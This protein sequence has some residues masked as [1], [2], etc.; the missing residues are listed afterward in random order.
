M[1]LDK[2]I[3]V[4]TILV[5]GLLLVACKTTFPVTSQ[6]TQTHLKPYRVGKYWYHPLPHARDFK[7]QGIASW[8]G[9]YFHGRK[10]SNGEVYDMYGMTAAHK[11]LPLGIYVRV[12]N[13]KNNKSIIVR[14]NDR[15]PFV[16]GRIIDLS[17]TAAKKLD[18]VE[19]GTAPVK[20]VALGAP[21]RS[22]GKLKYIKVDYFSGNFTLQVG[23]FSDRRNAQRLRE[24]LALKY[25]KAHITRHINSSRIY[26]RV[27]VGNFK[28]LDDAERLE[29]RLIS[30]GYPE[31]F[32]VAE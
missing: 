24:K 13:L 5:I 18:I 29:Q 11:T 26:Y 9:G 21:S 7:E 19:P 2:R 8:Y 6:E 4:L 28:K 15:G 25:G 3:S 14:I 16:R 12:T 10:T 1:G 27:R 20:V 31:A 32:I 23:A 22:S 17:Y 30:G